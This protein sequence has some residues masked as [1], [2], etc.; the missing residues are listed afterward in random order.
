M[1]KTAGTSF[2][3]T[4]EDYYDSKLLKDYTDLPI[5][6]PV[7]N[8]N[9]AALQASLNN[10]EK[11]FINIECIH[12][13]FLP[14]KYLLLSN[15][16]KITFITWMRNPIERLFSHYYFWKNNFNPKTAP[17]LHKK[18]IEEEWSIERFCLAS[19]L[20]DVYSQFLFGFPLE[21]FSFIGITEFYSEDLEFFSKHY[22]N[23]IMKPKR[24]NV[25]TK[26]NYYHISESLRDK[27][28]TFHSND[29][30]LYQRAL[31]IRLTRVST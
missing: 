22:L 7:F 23:T 24:I 28:E 26:E 31:E 29:M 17:L 16:Q 13:H 25:G 6:T 11:K 5:N 3:A 19:E 18:V 10:L 2:V 9:K 8:R 1:P 30:R 4:L 14:I 20:K 12:G 21:N 15:K 27:I